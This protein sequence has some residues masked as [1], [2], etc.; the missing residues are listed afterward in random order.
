[1]YNIHHQLDSIFAHFKVVRAYERRDENLL[2]ANWHQVN[3][4]SGI[5]FAV[6]LTTA[7]LQVYMIRRLFG[8]VTDPK[9]RPA[10]IHT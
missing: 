1:M 6:M 5:H 2:E 7:V 8:G 10:Q 4:W 3:L 9:S